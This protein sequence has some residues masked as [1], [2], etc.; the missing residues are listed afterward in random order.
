MST[1]ASIRRQTLRRVVHWQLAVESLADLEHA[2]SPTAWGQLGSR[3]GS[4]LREN[5]S[6]TVHRMQVQL[7]GLRARWLSSRNLDDLDGLDRALSA[8]RHRYLQ[9][10][11]IVD[12]YGD[13]VNSRTNPELGAMLRAFDH[14]AT[15]SMERLLTPLGVRVPPVLTYLD[16]G[17]GA[18]IL[19]EGARL[20]DGST[21]SRVAAIKITFH[22]RRRPTSLLHEVGHQVAH[23]VGWNAVLAEGLAASLR[24][25]SPSVAEI[26]SSW[27]SEIAADCFAL[28]TGGFGSVAALA[29]VLGGASPEIFR[30]S[31]GDP[32]PIAFLRVLFGVV[33]CRRLYGSGPWDEL[34][35]DWQHRYPLERGAGDIRE[36]LEASLRLLPLAVETC[37]FQPA[38][39]FGN[40]PLAE[41]L[42]PQSVS[43]RAL[44]EWSRQQAPLKAGGFN[45]VRDDGARLIALT[46]LLLAV[47]PENFLG[48]IR[49]YD[50]SM[51]LLGESL[52]GL[53]ALQR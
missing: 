43:P 47:E 52:P 37:F 22:N 49:Q 41:C 7:E 35:E 13:A 40:R 8:F 44:T 29:D 39:C 33:A 42:N 16:K 14:V 9:S 27:S 10:E 5:L 26:W 17:L 21:L 20:W 6:T 11:M 2:A 4:A 15:A 25:V 31:P 48:L 1:F 19:K 53:T 38:A 45:L 18:S 23:L 34:S 24:H 3:L 51:I 32:H 50:R 12:F 30:Y 28:V 46:S 36:F